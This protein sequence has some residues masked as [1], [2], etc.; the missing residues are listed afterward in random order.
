M[1]KGFS[2]PILFRT[3]IK[4][5][6]DNKKRIFENTKTFSLDTKEKSKNAYFGLFIWNLDFLAHQQV[7]CDDKFK[8]K[9]G[10]EIR[11]AFHLT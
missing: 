10:S 11:T 7:Q 5:S 1:V 8:I 2:F 9:G 4:A 6:S 3:L